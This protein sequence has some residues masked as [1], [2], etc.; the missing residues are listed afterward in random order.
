MSMGVNGRAQ[1]SQAILFLPLHMTTELRWESLVEANSKN[2]FGSSAT[3]VV[4]P[5]CGN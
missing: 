5:F 2:G 1:N 3:S 4:E